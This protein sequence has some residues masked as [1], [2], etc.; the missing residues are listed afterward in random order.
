MAGNEID[1]L[2]INR[3]LIVAPAGCG[4]TQLLV[5]GISRHAGGKPILVLTHTN[6]GVVALRSRLDKAGVKPSS[7]RLITIDAWAIR[8]ISTFPKRASHDSAIIEK[9]NFREIRKVAYL[10]LEA[11]HVN[12]V[13]LA[14]YDRVFVDE[15]Q[16]CS[17]F[18]HAIVYYLSHILPT[19]VVGDPMQAI[20]GFGTDR[21]ADWD[22]DVRTHF[23]VVAQL[24]M[25]WRWLN[26]GAELLG[27]WL[28]QVRNKLLA[29]EPVD[30]SQAP[31]EVTWVQI[32]GAEKDHL[33]LLEVGRVSSP[34]GKGTVLII[35][36][37]TKPESQQR[38]ASQTP[39]AETVEAV[40]LR[41]LILFA[42]DF[43]IDEP[44]A[45]KKIAEFAEKVMTNVGAADL[46]QRMDILARG[47]SVKA[48]TDVERAALA[49]QLDRTYHRVGD[50]LLEIN[51]KAGVHV[52]RPA[53]LRACFTALQ[54][55]ASSNGI[56]FEEAAIQVRDQ[57]RFRGRKIPQRAV[58]STLL[59]KGLEAEVA[60]IL[61]A[62]ILNAQNLY[63]AITRGSKRLLIC[64]QGHI[65]N[66]I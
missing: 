23:P 46:A 53:V 63:V 49:F 24:D 57:N 27:Q 1:L 31:S 32:D 66:P 56:S 59:L 22:S 50:L 6:A 28:L 9:Q 65:L 42:L 33:K 3:G 61:N 21:L 30:L 60:V 44:D 25:P 8:F 45:T 15:Y 16:D 13:I 11:D 12:D 62:D 29:T 51:K 26:A 35:G 52:F 48:P 4:K 34:G 36:D 43:E 37:S 19:C 47:T 5:D 18:Q 41:D 17:I 39:G 14:S 54:L 55:C 10:L 64:S 2:K 40:H 38:F 7:Y 58:G 20:F